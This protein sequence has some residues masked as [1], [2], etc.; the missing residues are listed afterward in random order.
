MS[1]TI[2]LFHF[3]Q[4]LTGKSPDSLEELR[5]I[6]FDAEDED[7][8]ERQHGAESEADE[9]QDSVELGTELSHDHNVPHKDDSTTDESWNDGTWKILNWKEPLWTCFIW[10][11]LCLW[12]QICTFVLILLPLL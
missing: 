9:S 2:Y 12:E 8:E 6:A 10:T 1:L 3:S 4:R 11:F 7:Q 5:E